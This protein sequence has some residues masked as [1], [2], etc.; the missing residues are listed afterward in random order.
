[1]KIC[2]PDI[3]HKSDIGGVLLGV[4]GAADV[5]AGFDA[6]IERARAYAPDARISGVLVS[7]QAPDG[8]DMIVG[9]RRDP[10]FG[11]MIMVGLGGIF[12]EVMEDVCIAPAPVDATEARRMVESLR[13]AALLTGARGSATLDVAALCDAIASLSRFAEACGPSLASVD[14]N[15]LRVLPAGEGVRVL[16]ALVVP[17]DVRGGDNGE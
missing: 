6:L 17:A 14:V 16:D 4:R 15:P 7:P 2:S 9:V 1:M 5:A 12:V 13:G 8:V 11:A 3:A 10:L